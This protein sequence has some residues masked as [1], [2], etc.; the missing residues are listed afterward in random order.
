MTS[1][2]APAR[3][4][5]STPSAARALVGDEQ[6][7]G[8]DDLQGEE[9]QADLGAE[10]QRGVGED[11]GEVQRQADEEQAE[12][13]GAGAELGGEERLPGGEGRGEGGHGESSE[14]LP[15]RAARMALI[16]TIADALGRGYRL[17]GANA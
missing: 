2:R 10:R 11:A 4:R 13:R 14:L 6:G 9:H 8:E 3:S 15:T 17:S 5:A 16:G 7:R 12:E 1:R